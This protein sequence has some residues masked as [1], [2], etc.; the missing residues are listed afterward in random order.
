[1]AATD[2]EAFSVADL[3]QGSREDIETINGK[4]SVTIYGDRTKTPCIA[5]PEVG[6]N[7]Q[8]CFQSLFVASGP[9]S[10]IL[11]NFYTIFIDPPG[12]EV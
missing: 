9:Q 3:F 11:K 4:I 5:Y 12:C 10:L 1:M 2:D 6:L 7:H 8:T